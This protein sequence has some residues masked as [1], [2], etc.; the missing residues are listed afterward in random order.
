MDH[1]GSDR[2][3]SSACSVVYPGRETA[4]TRR[5]RTFLSA[6]TAFDC[7]LSESD[8]HEFFRSVAIAAGAGH[9]RVNAGV[10]RP[11]AD[12][13]PEQAERCLI[14]GQ[15]VCDAAPGAEPAQEVSA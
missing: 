5:L 9:R 15:Q 1:N 6:A 12:A 11:A 3:E 2:P 14:P 8:F 4:A 7:A 10:R 13:N